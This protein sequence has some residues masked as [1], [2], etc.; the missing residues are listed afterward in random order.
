MSKR[1]KRQSAATKQQSA[2][3]RKAASQ[4]LSKARRYA[5][6]GVMLLIPIV[7]FA[8]LELGLRAGGFGKNL[9]LAHKVEE[10]GKTWWEIN[11]NVARRYFGLR[12]EFAR[13]AE[14][15]RVAFIKP[16]NGFRV[17]CLGESSMAGFPYNKNATMPGIIRT[18]LRKLLPDRE[19]EVVNLGIAAVNSYAVRDLIGEVIA[20]QPDVILVYV[21][22]NE[23]YG[24]LGV[25]S[26][27][28][29]GGNRNLVNGY[30]RLLHYRSFYL[31]Q[32]VIRKIA[33]AVR[34]EP[35]TLAES[36][37]PVMQQMARQQTIAYNSDVFV[38]ACE[39]F[40][41]N[42]ADIIAACKTAKTPVLIG[43]LVAN[44]RDQPPL[45]S[46]TAGNL[47]EAERERWQAAY[48]AG[49]Q[50]LHGGE[51]Q[52]ALKQFRAAAAIDS[53][54]AE[55]AYYQGKACFTS[56]DTT[57]AA[58]FFSQ[59]RDL[60]LLRFRA[61]RVF[62]AII[63][64]VCRENNIPIM[65]VESAFRKRSPGGIPG[66]ELVSEHLHPNVHGYVVMAKAFLQGLKDTNLLPAVTDGQ[67]LAQLSES[68]DGLNITV[69][70]EE[71]G[72]L[73]V[74][75]LT[76]AWPFKQQVNLPVEV[77]AAIAPLVHEIGTKYIRRQITWPDAHLQLAEKLTGLGQH[78]AA[79][80]EYQALRQQYPDEP[81]LLDNIGESLMS[82][83]RY[84]QAYAVFS[85]SQQMQPESPFPS[86]GVGKA[87]MFL[88][89]YDEAEKSFA[90]AIRRDDRTHKFSAA[91]RSVVLYLWGGA[92]TNLKRYD[93]AE[94]KF[95][96]ALRV[97]PNNALAKDFLAT[98]RAQL[99]R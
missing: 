59:A 78:Q 94:M 36:D 57:A 40:R 62:N 75:S 68:L 81:A 74:R 63:S 67:R 22:H 91:Y 16:A 19:I 97:D 53:T 98:L 80:A 13:Q 20:L 38:A 76:S 3:A 4:P 21:G 17:I 33:G 86:A 25:A 45:I 43:D 1:A 54:F 37:T 85:Q 46:E 27:F 32:E 11:P 71:I 39:I 55:L 88:A 48:A 92:L 9:A 5:F 35:E 34:S 31:L 42:L 24:A 7:C 66:A 79:L 82:L 50:L 60:D 87:C 64:E 12:P 83:Q 14:E 70:D 99:R 29:F 51:P 77:D 73:R 84:D 28:S 18:Y 96:E 2:P 47:T 15:G 8:I 44:L 26:N 52:A 10:D 89:K 30:L 95:L 23:F 90:E 41:H 93:Q 65:D 69:L 6:T 49:V 72:R 56:G 58:N 61:P